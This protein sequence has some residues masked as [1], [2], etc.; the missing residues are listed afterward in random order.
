MALPKLNT[1]TYELEVPSTDD[2]IK[3]RPF[4]VKEEK[5]LLMA[6]ESGKNEDVIQAVK[7]PLLEQG[8]LYQQTSEQIDGGICIETIFYGHGS[9]LKTGKMTLTIKLFCI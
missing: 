3:Y 4:L 1:P 8:I 2:K 7:E 9:E 5:I 6:L